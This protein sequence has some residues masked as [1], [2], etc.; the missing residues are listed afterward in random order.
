MKVI[1]IVAESLRA[2]GFS[3]LVNTDSPCGCELDDLAPCCDDISSCEAGYKHTDPR[4][5]KGHVWGIFKSPDAPSM[6][7]FDGLEC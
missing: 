1:E 3:G 7:A 2:K 5:R 6:E 4:E